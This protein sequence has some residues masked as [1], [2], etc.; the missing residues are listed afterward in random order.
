[1]QL[2]P[3]REYKMWMAWREEEWN[4]PSRD[5]YYIMALMNIIQ[6][7]F[8]KMMPSLDTFRVNFEKQVAGE[9][10]DPTIKSPAYIEMRRQEIL[11]KHRV[12]RL[13][14]P[15]PPGAKGN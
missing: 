12:K 8:G 6:G 4:K 2:I 11:G 9:K 7:L 1:M 5:N 14:G 15:R 13:P 10:K 3:Y